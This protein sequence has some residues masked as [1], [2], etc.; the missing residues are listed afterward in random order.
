MRKR[1]ANGALE[2]HVDVKDAYRMAH[3]DIFLLCALIAHQT[4]MHGRRAKK[5]GLTFAHVG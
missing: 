3:E 5:S 2:G 4:M 1:K